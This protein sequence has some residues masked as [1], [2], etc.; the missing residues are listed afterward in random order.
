MAVLS[1]AVTS[2]K[3]EWG[4]YAAGAEAACFPITRK[5]RSPVSRTGTGQ[6]E[7]SAEAAGGL[8]FRGTA[9]PSRL[10]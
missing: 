3:P 1:S 6:A 9:S 7:T 2:G 5:V 8:P 10:S 4:C